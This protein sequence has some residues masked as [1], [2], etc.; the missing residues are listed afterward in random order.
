M[1]TT[2][3]EPA[4]AWLPAVVGFT[5]ALCVTI[6]ASPPI[7]AAASTNPSCLGAFNTFAP[8]STIR[9][10]HVASG[11][12]VSVTELPFRDYVV[13]ALAAVLP[14]PTTQAA[15]EA[16]AIVVKQQAWYRA[17]HLREGFWVSPAACFDLRD[18]V[19][20]E[21]AGP[22]SVHPIHDDAV[23]ATWTITLRRSDLSEPFFFPY[24]RQADRPCPA[25][26]GSGQPIIDRGLIQ[27]CGSAGLT[28]P[29]I[30]RRGLGTSVLLADVVGLGGATRYDTSVL[31]SRQAVPSPPPM[32]VYVATG[33]AFPDAVTAGPAAA[34]EGGSLLLVP[35][36]SIP[37]AT[38]AELIRLHPS[39]IRIAGGPG[40]V[41]DG[42]ALALRAYAPIV[43]RVAGATRY[44]TALAISKASF[45][46][47]ATT[48][49]VATGRNFPDA[50]SAASAAA[51]LGSPVLLVPGMSPPSVAFGTAL[52]AELE[53]LNPSSIHVVGGPGVVDDSW[54]AW[55]GRFGASVDRLAGSDRYATAA[56]ISAA[57]Y[58]A[59]VDVLHL[60]TGAQFPDALVA[61]P[62]GGPLL[63]VPP[64][65]AGVP[66][67][68]REEAT[69]LGASRI[70]VLGTSM[71]IDDDALATL[72]GGGAAGP[73]GRLLGS[74]CCT[75]LPGQPLLD[76]DGVPMVV[77]AGKAEYNPVQIAQWGLSHHER[78]MRL[79][80]PDD[81]I[82]FLQ[83]ADW[84]ASHQ[85][86]DGLWPFTFAFGG[87]PVP[88]RSGLAQGQ[89]TSLLLRAWQ[90]TGD[91]GYRSAASA[92][93]ASMHRTFAAHGVAE[94]DGGNYWLEEYQSPYSHHTLNGMLLAMEGLR[95]WN[96]ATG[97]V[98]VDGWF[99]ETALTIERSIARFDTGSWSTYNIT[100][101]VASTKYHIIHVIMLRHLARIVRSPTLQVVAARWAGYA[102]NR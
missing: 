88:W 65:G 76:T 59:G 70:V 57:I 60:A 95:E 64:G 7:A 41:T 34:H 89:G 93:I 48:V 1:S 2:A 42:V 87:Q 17:I 77:Y 6:L 38:I 26:D 54:I 10:A 68:T 3:R 69:R 9:L 84:L 99:R 72:A 16:A 90:E 63:L 91:A 61:A 43:E 22:G 55:L 12:V 52:N 73:G 78:W 19:D 79:G 18:D 67:T 33:V 29:E 21:P 24:L 50:I 31:A 58:P 44:E 47:G 23:T 81:R 92:A 101:T 36:A 5:V 28:M 40:A 97:D 39:L 11:A 94:W 30:I 46:T 32:T 80:D 85:L 14:E 37:P 96:L 98:I 66:A 51:H 82:V 71:L 62:L 75:E 4:R 74:Y 27:S 35:S 20:V 53:R 100:G 13:R 83:M 86:P 56:A 49:F 25:T 102:S 8:P 15:A 45:P